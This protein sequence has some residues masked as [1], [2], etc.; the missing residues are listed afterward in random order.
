MDWVEVTLNEDYWDYCRN[1]LNSGF[2]FWSL[3]YKTIIIII[4]I[5]VIII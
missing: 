5:I 4:I 1:I 2:N 3:D